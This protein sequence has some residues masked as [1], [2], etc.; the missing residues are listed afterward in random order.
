VK[1]FPKQTVLLAKEI[2]GVGFTITSM[3]DELMQPFVEVPVTV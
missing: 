1:E 3:V 2:I